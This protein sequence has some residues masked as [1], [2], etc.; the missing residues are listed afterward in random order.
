MRADIGQQQRYAHSVRVARIAELLARAHGEN[1]RRARLAGMLHDLARL[2]PADR[3][4]AECAT[5]GISIDD[6][7]RQHPVV[8]HARIGAE[9]ARERYGVTDEGVLSA[10]RAHTLGSPDMS[11]LDAVVFL[12]DALEPGRTFDGREVLLRLARHDLDGAIRGVLESSASY[13]RGRGLAVAPLTT[14]A[15]ARYG[16]PGA[17]AIPPNGTR[18]EDHFC[19]T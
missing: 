8:L 17:D 7:E 4:L 13:L 3:L 11:R 16:A 12:A 1:T 6:F 5:R 10:I 19:P 18:M 14:A 2:Y 15:L 9:L